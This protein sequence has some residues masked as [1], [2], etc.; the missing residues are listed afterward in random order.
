[1]AGR[2]GHAVKSYS[3]GSAK[4]VNSWGIDFGKNNAFAWVSQRP[5]GAGLAP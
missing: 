5:N 4:R 2:E 3:A 1:M